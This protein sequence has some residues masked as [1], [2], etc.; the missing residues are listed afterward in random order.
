MEEFRSDLEDFIE[1]STKERSSF[2]ELLTEHR[3]KWPQ[4]TDH[5]AKVRLRTI[6][7]ERIEERVLSVYAERWAE[8]DSRQDLTSEEAI[9][10]VYEED[11]WGEPAHS[12]WFHYISSLVK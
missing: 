11:N 7:V 10:A 9:R 6:L 3:Q 1:I 12:V 2:F 8:A 4:V 5:N